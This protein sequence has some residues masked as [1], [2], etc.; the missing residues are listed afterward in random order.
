[1]K[2]VCVISEDKRSLTFFKNRNVNK[3]CISYLPDNSVPKRKRCVSIYIKCTCAC[4][5]VSR[6]ATVEIY[7]DMDL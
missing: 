2:I 5:C 1:M 4:M 3:L 7:P 6:R